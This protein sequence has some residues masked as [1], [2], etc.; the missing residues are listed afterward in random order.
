MGHP[1][2]ANTSHVTLG[3]CVTTRINA[4]GCNEGLRTSQGNFWARVQ[5]RA[6]LGTG[7]AELKLS[8]Q[9]NR[10]QLGG[11]LEPPLLLTSPAISLE[12]SCETLSK[13]AT[14]PGN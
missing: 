9:S 8:R 12:G 13:K 14:S 6:L 2:H 11:L 4:R 3:C 1:F 10:P 5:G 7:R